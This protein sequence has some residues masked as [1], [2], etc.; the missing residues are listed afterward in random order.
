MRL[1]ASLFISII[2]KKNFAFNYMK[3]KMERK[4]VENLSG[5]VID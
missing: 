5:R 2:D 1:R 3:N 4:K